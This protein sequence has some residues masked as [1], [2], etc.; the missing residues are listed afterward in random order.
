MELVRAGP[1]QTQIQTPQNAKQPRTQLMYNS[2]WDQIKEQFFMD[3]EQRFQE[4]TPYS[5]INNKVQFV[6]GQVIVILLGIVMITA[7]RKTQLKMYL[8]FYA[9]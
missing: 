9:E 7:S 2:E 1:V 8:K 3:G 6:S 4:E 5:E